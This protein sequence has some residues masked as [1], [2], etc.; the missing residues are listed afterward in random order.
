[1][2]L[3]TAPLLNFD[4]NESGFLD[5][6]MDDLTLPEDRNLAKL[7]QDKEKYDKRMQNHF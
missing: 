6:N 4:W 1:M 3:K 2:T 5:I 7:L